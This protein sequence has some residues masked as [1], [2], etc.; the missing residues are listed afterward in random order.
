MLTKAC[1]VKFSAILGDQLSVMRLG[2]FLK[3][4]KLT[5][6]VCAHDPKIWEGWIFVFADKRQ[7]QVSPY[8]QESV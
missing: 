4:A 8:F 2:D 6:K 1:L 3:A 7:L 5:P